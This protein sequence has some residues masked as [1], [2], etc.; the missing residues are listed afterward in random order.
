MEINEAF[1]KYLK[2]LRVEKNLSIN[3]ISSY[4]FDFLEFL[5]CFKNIKDTNDI[6]YNT[7]ENFIFIESKKKMKSKTIARRISSLKNF[8]IFL[9]IE[10]IKN[11]IIKSIESPKK[12]KKLPSYLTIDEVNLFLKYFKNNSLKNDNSFRD[13]SI[14]YT[15][16]SCGLRVSELINLEIKNI[17]L[18]ENLIKIKGKGSKE[19][20]VPINYNCL[21]IIQ[22]YVK[23][24]RNKIKIVDKNI[25]YLNK[26]GKKISRQYIFNLIKK[27]INDLKINKN[28]SPHSLRHS[29][30]THLLENGADL[31]IVQ[32]ILGHSNIETTEIYTHISEDKKLKVYDLYWDKK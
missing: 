20:E 32:E 4:K 13:Y 11:D 27:A 16:Y 19:R 22:E 23:K 3:S 14:I 9:E 24:I 2:Y 26:K 12:E 29:F 17:N 30:A 15:M 28:I 21:C 18:S 8:F 7:L 31:R 25:L 1:D 6:T 5:K 10:Q